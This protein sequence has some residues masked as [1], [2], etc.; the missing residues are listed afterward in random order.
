MAAGLALIDAV[1]KA[2]AQVGFE[3]EKLIERGGHYAW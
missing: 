1:A 2:L 3:V